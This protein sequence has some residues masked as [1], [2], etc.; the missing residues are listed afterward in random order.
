MKKQEVLEAVNEFPKEI[1]LS[2]LFERLM[3]IEKIEKG[4]VQIDQ[5]ETIPQEK[6]VA[7]FKNK[8]RK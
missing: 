6:V 5:N 8:W 3:V 7:H 4:L 2:D 1:N